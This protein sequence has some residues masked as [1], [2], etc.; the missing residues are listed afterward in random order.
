M[1]QI[2]LLYQEHN[3]NSVDS[4]AIPCINYHRNTSL[5]L[6]D[7]TIK[8]MITIFLLNTFLNH[9]GM[10]KII[11]FNSEMLYEI[12]ETFIIPIGSIKVLG[13]AHLYVLYCM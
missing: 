1:F 5:Y 13:I 12:E 7:K 9:V 11:C 2:R 6:K 8:E 4:I 3:E 10:S